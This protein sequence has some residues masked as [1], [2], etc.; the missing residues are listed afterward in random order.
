MRGTDLSNFDLQCFVGIFVCHGHS[1]AA[2]R[3]SIIKHYQLIEPRLFRAHNH[4]ISLSPTL[5]HCS[6]CN[7][8]RMSYGHLSKPQG[9]QVAGQHEGARPIS[10]SDS[11]QAPATAKAQPYLL[12]CCMLMRVHSSRTSLASVQTLRSRNRSCLV[13]TRVRPAFPQ[14]A[15]TIQKCD[16][17]DL[18]SNG[19]PS[20]HLDFVLNY[21]FLSR[22]GC[23]P[24]SG[25][26]RAGGGVLVH[27]ALQVRKSHFP[28]YCC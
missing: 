6:T 14:S 23:A 15:A 2:S 19:K 20:N 18:S 21:S 22:Q 10:S 26:R 12:K 5:L 1:Q 17:F 4:T 3:Q 28:H 8:F 7:G 16:M 24:G 13:G 27:L 25:V 9:N 11:A